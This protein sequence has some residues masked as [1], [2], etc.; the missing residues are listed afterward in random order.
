MRDSYE[1]GLVICRSDSSWRGYTRTNYAAQKM[2]I[3][4]G[5]S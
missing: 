1:Q 2:N 5:V 4:G 3:T